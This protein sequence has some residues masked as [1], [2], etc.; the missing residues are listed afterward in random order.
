MAIKS[1]KADIEVS[2]SVGFRVLVIGEAS[3]F[4]LRQMIN[5]HRER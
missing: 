4:R 2:L 1:I 5:S 3:A